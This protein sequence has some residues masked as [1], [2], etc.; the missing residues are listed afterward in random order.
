MRQA[1]RG[2]DLPTADARAAVAAVSDATRTT[3]QRRPPFS[4]KAAHGVGEIAGAGEIAEIG[5]KLPPRL[6][7][8]RGVCSGPRAAMPT[9]PAMS[10]RSGAI[11]GALAST[12]S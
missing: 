11:A 7:P 10:V 3:Q 12:R 4:K 5:L 6:R 1:R 2:G 8:A 9:K